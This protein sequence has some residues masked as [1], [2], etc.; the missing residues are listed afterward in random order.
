[1]KAPTAAPAPETKLPPLDSFPFNGYCSDCGE[2]AY[3]TPSGSVCKN[4]HGNAPVLDEPPAK[5]KPV[6]KPVEKQVDKPAAKVTPPVEKP[7]PKLEFDFSTINP[8]TEW[9]C[10]GTYEAGNSECKECPFAKQCEVK[11]ASKSK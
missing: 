1:M 8:E 7:K 9:E 10:F 11:K 6:E 5:Q 4:G 2:P 3:E